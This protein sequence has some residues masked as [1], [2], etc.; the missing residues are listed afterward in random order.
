MF[1]CPRSI[2][3][4]RNG[5]KARQEELCVLEVATL[6]RELTCTTGQFSPGK[7]DPVMGLKNIFASEFLALF[8]IFAVQ[9]PAEAPR[10]HLPGNRAGRGADT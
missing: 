3:L 9:T 5:R 10:F 8:A 1:R 7:D 2:D 4:N 6:S